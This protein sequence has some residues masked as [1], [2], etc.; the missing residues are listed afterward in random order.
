MVFENLHRKRLTDKSVVIV[1]EYL[2]GQNVK[3]RATDGKMND[4]VKSGVILCKNY[5]LSG[6]PIHQETEFNPGILYSFT[7]P[8]F[9]EGRVVCPNCGGVDEIGRFSDGCP[10]CGAYYNLEY[11]GKDLGARSH[12]DYVVPEKK[13]RALPLLICA[14]ICTVLSM[15]FTV[16]LSRTARPFDFIKGA[17]IGM[18]IGIVVGL[19]W[20]AVRNPYVITEK[21]RRKK[22]EQESSI[23][24]VK[25]RLEADG[26]SFSVFTNALSYALNDWF[27]GAERA[28]NKDVIDFDILDCLSM[29]LLGSADSAYRVDASLLLRVV[30]CKENKVDSKEYDARVGLRRDR[31]GGYNLKAGLNIRRCPNCGSSVDLSALRCE[32]C[33]SDIEYRQ[34]FTVE[35]I[36]LRERNSR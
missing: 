10:Y 24:A 5:F 33:G 29:T 15:V 2:D 30:S 26:D 25:K 21:A 23:A 8:T 3:R 17:V 18:L 1:S 20:N 31:S 12:G 6:A 11:V 14:A 36:D 32:Y 22:A 16:A 19:I 9:D 28:E 4:D 35:S 34:P 7:F 13:T 27:Y